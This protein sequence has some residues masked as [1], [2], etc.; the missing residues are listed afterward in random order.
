MPTSG[1]QRV[2]RGR[3]ADARRARRRRGDRWVRS[4]RG[5]LRRGHR[6][7]RGRAACARRPPGEPVGVQLPL[8][9]AR[10]CPPQW[11]EVPPSCPRACSSASSPSRPWA[12]RS[13]PAFA[14]D[15]TTSGS[16]GRSGSSGGM[17]SV[18]SRRSRGRSLPSAW[19]WASHSGI[20]AGRVAWQLVAEQIGVRASAT[21]SPLELLIVALVACLAGAAL[22]CQRGWSRP[23]SGR[24]TP[25]ERNSPAATSGIPCTMV[26]FRNTGG[27]LSDNLEDRRAMGG[28]GVAVG[29]RHRRRHRRRAAPAPRRRWRRGRR[30]RPQRRVQPDQPGGSSGTVDPADEPLVRGDVGRPRR[31]PGL[32]GDRRWP[33]RR[34]PGRQLVLFTDAREHRRMW[35]R[36]RRRSVPSTARPT[37]GIHRP[38][39]LQAAAEPVRRTRRLRSRLRARPR[40]RAPRAEPV[41]TSDEV[42]Q[43]QQAD[44]GRGKRAVGRA[45]SSRPT[46]TPAS[47]ATPRRTAG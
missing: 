9:T 18:R 7:G 44:R 16:C 31:H 38:V 36:R 15:V 30:H 23:D 4:G 42:R 35:Q 6:R 34:L 37:E 11:R 45:S 2:Q 26:K 40:A 3:G 21:T 29:R 22:A 33:R 8:T 14:A 5:H 27:G 46:A 20:A 39:L 17:S 24:W 47:G 32:L 1:R 12:M 10:R 13:P 19:S 28:R 41:G 43:Q 25:C